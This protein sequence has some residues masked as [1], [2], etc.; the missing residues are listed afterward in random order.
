MAFTFIACAS[1]SNDAAATTLDTATSLNV[2]VGDLLICW[3]ANE[4][5]STT[6]AVAKST[7]SPAN[8]FTFDAGDTVNHTDAVLSAAFG[9]VLS[10]AADATAT[11]R[12]T[13]TSKDFRRLL[14]MQFRPDAGAT[15]TKDTSNHSA[16]NAG[17]FTANSGVI[18]T[19]GTDEVV[20][21]SMAE[22]DG[23]DI[24]NEQIN[25]VASTE[26][27]GSPV[28]G[29]GGAAVNYR[30]LTATFAGGAMTGDKSSGGNYISGI[31]AFK[32]AGAPPVVSNFV[33]RA[34]MRIW[35]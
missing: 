27:V 28:P 10:A 22:D 8:T 33:P 7:G 9:Y 31:I 32:S 11:F 6:R 5:G 2:A 15:V 4:S 35:G 3:C 14:V 17:G 34:G 13:T 25:T 16:T 12:L 20:V 19:T 18:T 29:P 24:T 26:P 21:G 23:S 1:G 30:I